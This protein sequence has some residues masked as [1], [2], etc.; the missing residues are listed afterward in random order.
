MKYFLKIVL[1][2]AA[3][4]ILITL[5]S[6][7]DCML[8]YAITTVSKDSTVRIWEEPL[9]IPTYEV[10]IPDPNPRF[11][12]GRAYQGAQGRVYPYPML[13]RL[14][15][16][17]KDKTYNA[18]YL[19]N[20]YIKICILPE[21]GGRIFYAIDKTNNHDFLY[22]QHVIKPAL[23]G[24]L[25]AWIS[26]GI[27]WNFPH[28]HRATVFMP[29]DYTFQENPDG[30]KTIWMSEIEIRH[31]MRWVIGITLY[32]G[33]S[34]FE[35]AFK[36]INRTPVIHSFLYWA[37]V[38]TH[39]NPDYQVIFPPGTEYA[40]YHSKNAFAH[41][42]VSHEVYRGIDYSEGVDLS[43]WKNHPSPISF[44]AWNYEDDFL[45]GYDHEKNAG[46]VYVANH[47]L[48]P[49]KKLWEWGPGPQGRIWDEILTETDGPYAEIM[50]GAYSDN[51]PDYSWLQPYETKTV[52]QYWYPIREM[53]GVKNANLKAAVDLR[54]TP[55]NMA[56]IGFSTTSAYE[57]AKVLLKAGNKVI[58][59]QEINISPGEPFQKKILLPPGVK[60][61]DLQVSLLSSANEEL[62]AY[63]PVKKKDTPMPDVVEPPPSPDDIKTV[64]ELYLAGLRLEQFYNPTLEPYPYYEEALKRDPG[65]Y[66]VNIALGI[67]NYKGGMLKEAEE[68]FRTAIK[69]ATKNYTSPRD[70]EAYYYLG[71]ILQLQ[72]KYDDAYNA[73][74]KA[75]W[76]YESQ[77][78]AYFHI[79][80][81]DCKMGD[82]PTALKHINLSIITN[83]WNTN[84]LNL[85]TAILRHLGQYGEAE[86]I[87]VKILSDDPLNLWAEFELFLTQSAMGIEEEAAKVKNS[88]MAKREGKVQHWYKAQTF[89]EIAVDYSNCGLWDEAITLLS[90]LTDS[91]ENN[92]TT[93]PLVYYYLGYFWQQKGDFEKAS[94]YYRFGSE[95][96]PD[97]CFP[98][99][100]ESIG[101]LQA[102]FRNN[103]E[104]ARAHYYLGN[105][106]YDHQ[107]E[108]AIL[109]WE[110]SRALD[111]NL[112]TVN[113]NLGLAYIQVDNDIQKAIACL[114][115]AVACDSTDP[116]LFYELDVLYEAGGVSPEIRLALMQKNHQTIVEHNDA[117]SREI[118]LLTQLGYYDDA[119]VFM[120]NYHFR[121]WEGLGNIHTTYVD[122]HLLRG[123]KYF[124]VK[125]YKEAIRDFEA[126][127][128]YPE[129]LEVARPYS[130]GRDCEVYYF[131]GLT[132][133]AEGKYKK[134]KEFFEKS[135]T[136]KRIESWSAL[137]YYQGLAF[138]KT[139]QKNKANQMFDGLIEFGDNKLET[140]KKEGAVMRF[141]AKFG[142]KRSRNE[143]M[144]DAYYLVGLGYMGKGMLSEAKT[145]FEKTLDLNIN[146]LWAKVQL[147]GIQ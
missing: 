123:Q 64:E 56:L 8:S 70:G 112:A 25:G 133:E 113:R 98:F 66:R 126:A 140:L 127:L 99:R 60:K 118:V 65:N 80:E 69:R 143:L 92:E 50:V 78:A 102:A 119:I 62:I 67:L 36:F 73:F 30:S 77:S 23:I 17:R 57:K 28:H 121:R 71:L 108:N 35:A 48:A 18:V 110:K 104:D 14:T 109:E 1:F 111:N 22:H 137:S 55:E 122:A 86:N 128:K 54:V 117:F 41:W 68:K 134:A 5:T 75:V 33:K 101:M 15:D 97:Y 145:S 9:V 34:Y 31:R 141:F 27:E 120:N 6:K 116:R 16:N 81:I 12:A 114:E 13:D 90:L 38:S 146:H 4:I 43:W 83:I 142:N 3:G 135:I 37:N 132:Y 138:Q 59:Q 124:K 93:Y 42:P 96:P 130:G 46:T 47:Y 72:G 85:K 61:E 7:A 24:M 52:S 125:Q 107:P 89:L 103:P 40:T 139:G 58:F 19:E 84:A 105:L 63:K 100:T 79:S 32:P 76:S 74:Y 39:A 45:A 131:M 2:L 11:Y 53:E 21:I 26:G 29:I 88:L 94:K 115:K 91:V 95:M 51:Q 106:Y 136:A 129:N 147:S 49:G 10:G 82:F 20:E 44:F 87:S 144:A